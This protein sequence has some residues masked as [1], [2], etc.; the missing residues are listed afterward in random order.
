MSSGAI[1]S[2]DCEG[3]TCRDFGRSI[4]INFQDCGGEK[5][6]KNLEDTL[7]SIVG[8]VFTLLPGK[9]TGLDIDRRGRVRRRPKAAPT[10]AVFGGMS[11]EATIEVLTHP[12]T[13][14]C[15]RGVV[16][17]SPISIT[18]LIMKRDGA[19]RVRDV[20]AE[21]LFCQ[22]LGLGRSWTTSQCS[23]QRH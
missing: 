9:T 5:E 19:P 21:V 10:I 12:V 14:F 11:T 13:H 20:G 16:I 2:G 3:S 17:L 7:Y 18:R 1:Y 4:A 22:D 23:I 15:G 6:G 8:V